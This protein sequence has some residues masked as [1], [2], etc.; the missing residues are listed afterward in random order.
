MKALIYI[1]VFN[2]FAELPRVL[3]E[4]AAAVAR[5][6][7]L[8][9]CVL[10]MGADMHVASLFP[11]A[12]RLAEALSLDCTATVLPMR[13][14]G[15]PEPR[16]TLTAPALA[17]ARHVHLLIRGADKRAALETAQRTASVEDAPARIVLA[18]DDLVIHY[19]ESEPS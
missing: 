17:T 15:A 14:P 9:V 13:A 3:D 19:A 7:P 12:D 18:R 1:P 4:I 16:M 11:G 5:I 10:G 2:Q 6:L 8:D